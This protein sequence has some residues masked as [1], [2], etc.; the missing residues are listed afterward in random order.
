MSTTIQVSDKT[1]KKLQKIRI[2][3]NFKTLDGVIIFLL[4][5]VN[6]IKKMVKRK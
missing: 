4:S 1:W 2:N 5:L 6:K 3:S